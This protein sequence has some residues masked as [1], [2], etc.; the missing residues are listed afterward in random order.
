[1]KKLNRCEH[2]WKFWGRIVTG[3]LVGDAYICDKCPTMDVQVPFGSRVEMEE[4]LERGYQGL[5]GRA[6]EESNAKP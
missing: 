1:M 5:E 4:V 2:H 6:L 3:T